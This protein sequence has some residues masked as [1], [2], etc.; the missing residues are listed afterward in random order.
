MTDVTAAQ[1]GGFS[2]PGIGSLGDLAKRGDL[3]LAIG[4]LTILM[5]LILLRSV[6]AVIGSR[7]AQAHE[8]ASKPDAIPVCHQQ[9]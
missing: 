3:A 2:L 6:V 9:S 5:V 4:V 7:A 8:S 1:S